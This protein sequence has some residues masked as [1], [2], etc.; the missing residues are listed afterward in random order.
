MKSSPK[1]LIFSPSSS[2]GIAEHTFYQAKALE[3]NGAKVLCLVSP[4]FLDGRKSEFE[5]IPCLPDP[6]EGASGIWKKLRM[7]WRII[8]SRYILA[9]QIIR[10]RPDLVLLDSY[11]EYL[12]P[13]WVDPHIFLS[14]IIGFRYAANLHDPVRSYV[15]GP[16]WWHRLSVWLAYQPLDFVLVHHELADHSIVPERVKVVVAPHGL[17]DVNLGDFEGQRVSEE[18]GI[19]PGQKVFLSFGYVRDG[20]NLDLAIRALKE[21]SEAVLVIAGTVAST[22]DKTFQDYKDLAQQLGVAGRCRFFEGYLR[23][24]ELGRYFAG[25]DYVLLTYSADFHS[26][27]GVL[28]LAAKARK[29]V[30]ASASPSPMI[31]A[32]TRYHL[33]VAVKPDSSEAIVEGMKKLGKGEV[34]PNWDAYEASASWD[35]NARRVLETGGFLE[36]SKTDSHKMHKSHKDC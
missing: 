19:Q 34:V 3:K 32:V 35:L 36:A 22:K 1:I 21:V 7:A 24:E 6:V 11:V 20:K 30:L 16:K 31:E 9:W 10:H 4:S 13:L 12:A 5:T 25:T 18:W 26:Q 8:S 2:G 23:D 28:N 17:Y 29:P 15:I 33:G 27:S 14:R